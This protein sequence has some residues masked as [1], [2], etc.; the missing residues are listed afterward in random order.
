MLCVPRFV[1]EAGGVVDL[2]H[3]RGRL[4][5]QSW[6]GLAEEHALPLLLAAEAIWLLCPLARHGGVDHAAVPQPAH[7]A[8][9]A[10]A[11][12]GGVRLRLRRQR[13][14]R[15]RSGDPRVEEVLD[16][17]PG[18][19]RER[20][21]VVVHVNNVNVSPRALPCIRALRLRTVCARPRRP[22]GPSRACPLPP[23]V[24]T[25]INLLLLLL[26]L[27]AV[28]LVVELVVGLGA[29]LAKVNRFD[30]FVVFRVDVG[31][32]LRQLEQRQ[33]GQAPSLPDTARH[34]VL[35]VVQRAVLGAAAPSRGPLVL[36]VPRR[37]RRRAV[38]LPVPARAGTRVTADPGPIPLLCPKPIVA[39]LLLNEH[40]QPPD[41]RAPRRRGIAA[42]H[43]VSALHKHR[44]KQRRRKPNTSAF[45]PSPS[46][47]G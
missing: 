10:A 14:R 30:V 26:L 36:V 37:G 7:P 12:G 9:A 45:L 3:A 17:H 22:G 35:G 11:A 21:Q 32:F 46:R 38:G 29:G 33:A 42:L 20:L 28:E 40:P 16:V 4:L 18:P 43:T 41:G 47:Q 19:C 5:L 24:A 15:R 1:L 23:L 13:R 44:G 31:A 25:G 8:M 34:D 39:L 2:K 27:L 6:R